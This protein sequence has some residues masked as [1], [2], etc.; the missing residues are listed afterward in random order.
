MLFDEFNLFGDLVFAILD[1]EFFDFA[2]LRQ[3]P[4]KQLHL[5]ELVKGLGFEAGL[6]SLELLHAFVPFDEFVMLFQFL[7]K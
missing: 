2:V 7:A 1:L 5:S 6:E 4:T 3:D